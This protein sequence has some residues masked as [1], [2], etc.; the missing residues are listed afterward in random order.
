MPS[1]QSLNFCNNISSLKLLC[2]SFPQTALCFNVPTV[3]TAL[4]TDV[5]IS[6]TLCSLILTIFKITLCS[7]V[8]ISNTDIALILRLHISALGSK[9]SIMNIVHTLTSLFWF[10]KQQQILH[11][12]VILATIPTKSALLLRVSFYP[13]SPSTILSRTPPVHFTD[14]M[15][16]FTLTLRGCRHT[17]LLTFL[18]LSV[19]PVVLFTS[20]RLSEPHIVSKAV[21]HISTD[22]EGGLDSRCNRRL[23][24]AACPVATRANLY[25]KRELGKV[26]SQKE[27]EGIRDEEEGLGGGG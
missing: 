14:L 3:H 15:A 22:L 1:Q 25:S 17:S 20:S 12:G 11:G 21:E 18:F 13:H 23:Q 9:V 6:N 10:S 5:P 2:T 16:N 26:I 27:S 19:L 24:A 7:N 8:P 4:F